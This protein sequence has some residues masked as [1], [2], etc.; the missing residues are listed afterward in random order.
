MRRY[1]IPVVMAILTAL[2]FNA[3]HAFAKEDDCTA[4]FAKAGNTLHIPCFSF[5]GGNYWLDIKVPSGQFK[6]GISSKGLLEIK[7]FGKKGDASKKGSASDLS[8]IDGVWQG[9]GF[10]ADNADTWTI[11]LTADSVRPGYEIEYPSL[12]CGGT[13]TLTSA[14][15]DTAWFTEHIEYGADNCIDGGIVAVTKINSSYITFTW[16]FPDETLEAWSTLTKQ[17]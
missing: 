3:G 9:S 4:T 5:D 6:D 12:S 7:G 11:K 2:V 10:Q 14:D 17:E 8:W 16:F 1:F 15:G 13:W